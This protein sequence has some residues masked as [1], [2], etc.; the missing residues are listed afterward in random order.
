MRRR[1]RAEVV[2][3]GYG[4]TFHA[5]A[6]TLISLVSSLRATPAFR[7]S[8]PRLPARS[9]P[10]CSASQSDTRPCR[11]VASGSAALSC[12]L[13]L[14]RERSVAIG[15]ILNR[16][17]RCRVLKLLRPLALL[18]CHRTARLRGGGKLQ[19]GEVYER[20]DNMLT[21]SAPARPV[22][23]GRYSCLYGPGVKS[24]TIS[25]AAGGP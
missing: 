17:S 10:T 5:S 13:E 25:K 21:P 12:R 22:S 23:S 4:F 19:V 16:S 18:E 20:H 24:H 2:A 3:V 11:G 6:Y 15:C 14:L 7:P 8:G 1:P 9:L